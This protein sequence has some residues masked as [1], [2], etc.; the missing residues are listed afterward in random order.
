M[1]GHL[2]G[3]IFALLAAL[4]WACALVLFKR[5]GESVPPL[6]LNLFKNTVGIVLLAATIPVVEGGFSV[7]RDFPRGDICILMLSGIIGIALADTVFFHALNLVGVGTISIVDCLYSPLIIL[8]SWL[9]LSEDLSAVHYLGA[10]L[11]LTGV[12]VSSRHDPAPGRTRAQLI[13]GLLLGATSMALMAFGIVIAKPVLN[14]FPL[15]WATMLRLIAGTL[16]LALV[17]SA[18]AKRKELWL[19]FKPSAVWRFSLPGA[20]LGAYLAMIFWIGG[21]KYTHASIAGILNQTSVIFA[22]ILAAVF[23]KESFGPRKAVAVTFAM[24]GVVLVTFATP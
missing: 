13:A 24:A 5:S 21:F 9:L 3:Q 18:S 17:I 15:L 12:F 1:A 20:V 4:T 10:G 7:L 11:I 8:F 16:I 23:L 6:A 2:L 19:A 22:I 14:D